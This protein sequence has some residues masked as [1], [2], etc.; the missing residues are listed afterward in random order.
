MIGEGLEDEA[1]QLFI[2]KGLNALKSVGYS[3]FFDFSK[4]RSQGKRQ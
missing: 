3:E 1:R 4:E 2:L